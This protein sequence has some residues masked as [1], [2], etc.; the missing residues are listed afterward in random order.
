MKVIVAMTCRGIPCIEYQYM[1]C[2]YVLMT[3]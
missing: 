3:R 1:R 2:G